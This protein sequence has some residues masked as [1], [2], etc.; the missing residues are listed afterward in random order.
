MAVSITW[1][2]GII[3]VPKADTVLIGTDPASGREIRTYDTDQFHKE[4]RA[5]LESQAGRP[6]PNTH[7]HDPQTTIDGVT[8]AAKIIINDGYYQVE[9]ENGTYRVVF[10][11]TNNNIATVSVV[12]SVSIAPTNSAGL[13]AGGGSTVWSTPEKDQIIADVIEGV[14]WSRKA[15][16]EAEQANQK[17]N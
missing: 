9:F 15:S 6:F 7:T 17:L 3:S 2:T 14:S 5:L 12:N 8:F 13:I 11:N 4:L 1:E 16:D 10:I